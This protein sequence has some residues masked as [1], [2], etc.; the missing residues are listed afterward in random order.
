MEERGVVQGTERER[1]GRG[2]GR[3]RER[4]MREGDMLN[5]GR[6]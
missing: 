2:E 6:D 4:W 3:V 1:E 5:E